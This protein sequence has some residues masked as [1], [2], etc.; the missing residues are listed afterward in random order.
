MVIRSKFEVRL[1]QGK[2]NA[3]L[4]RSR[5]G[6]TWANIKI[7]KTRRQTLGPFLITTTILIGQGKPLLHATSS[8]QGEVTGSKGL[9]F[10][11]S[12]GVCLG[13]LTNWLHFLG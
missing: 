12:K 10:Q 2:F 6:Q 5:D 11:V 4:L 9:P 8:L 7:F 3:L 13:W 1:Q